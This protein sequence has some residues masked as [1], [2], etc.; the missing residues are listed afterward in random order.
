MKKFY[1]ILFSFDGDYQKESPQFDNISD[2]WD[3]INDLGSK[4]YFYPFCFVASNKTI[5]DAPELLPFFIGKRITTVKK[6]FKKLYEKTKDQS[7]DVYDY[8]F[9]MSDNLHEKNYKTAGNRIYNYVVLK[10][11]TK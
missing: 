6:E 11:Q 9:A 1:A 2:V 5:H 4:W 7:L 3:F 8:M 10:N